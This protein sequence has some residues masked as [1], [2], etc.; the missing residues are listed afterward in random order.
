MAFAFW[1]G[2]D[3]ILKERIFGLTGGGQ[4]R[5][6]RQGVLVVPG[7]HPHPLVDALALRLSAGG[8][9]L[10]GPGRRQRRRGRN[11][12]EYEL[13]DTGAFDEDRY[14]DIDGRVRQG[15]R[16]TTSACASP[17]AT[18]GP[19]TATLHV[20]PT[21]WFRNR[22]PG[23]PRPGR[24]SIEDGTGA[25]WPRTPTLGTMTLGGDGA[26]EPLFC[27]Q[28]DQ[29]RAAA[30]APRRP[31]VPE[32]RDQRPRGRAARRRWTRAARA[33]RRP[34]VPAGGRGRARR[35]RSACGWRRELR[36]PRPDLDAD[37]DRPRGRGRRLLRRAGARSDRRT[38]RVVMRQAFAGML[39]SKQFYHYDVARWLDGDPGQPPPPAERLRG[40]NADW[41]HISN[42]DVI[43]MPDKWEYPWFAAWDLAFHCVALAHVD[44]AFA[45][46]QLRLITREWYMHPNGQ[47]PGVRVGLRR[48]QPAG[49][50][51]GR[52]R[53]FQHRRVTRRR[54]ARSASSTSCCW[55][56][57]GGPTPRTRRATTS[58]AAASSAWT[59]SARS[60]APRPCP[61]GTC[62]S[63]P[64]G[65]GGWPS[66]AWACSRSRSCWPATTRPTRT[67]R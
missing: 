64:T 6:G 58:S 46:A 10:R 29:R 13:L 4:P 57:P 35:P 44:P 14:W 61:T 11:E 38:R 36:R 22:G 20:L 55:A 23:T 51:A 16:P 26:P 24:R 50:R 41:R 45:K 48:R 59:T 9:P 32:G 28:R 30:R 63:R 2:R 39:W 65:P 25:S 27:E 54:V 40:R 18:P 60:T 33:R 8:L 53:V 37:A 21:M 17:S 5:R 43:S 34:L 66:T 31:A 15:R 12:P 7:L 52:A 42:H 49:P 56:S 1:N 67:W 3:P 19:T 62:W 47:L